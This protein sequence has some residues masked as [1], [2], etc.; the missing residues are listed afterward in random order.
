MQPE[1][2]K[3]RTLF[4]AALAISPFVKFS[5][6][7]CDNSELVGGEIR[8]HKAFPSRY[9]HSDSEIK[10]FICKVF[11]KRNFRVSHQ[12]H[13]R[14]NTHVGDPAAEGDGPQF[15]PWHLRKD[16][17]LEVLAIRD[18]GRGLLSVAQGH[19]ADECKADG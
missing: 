10:H 4:L 1:L 18:A 15:A 9:L 5:S 3:I 2:S 14:R 8:T 6:T 7:V 13:R 16:V 19:Q 12:N 17:V 11:L